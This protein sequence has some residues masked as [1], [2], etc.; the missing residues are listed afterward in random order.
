[1][2]EILQKVKL[3][4]SEKIQNSARDAHNALVEFFFPKI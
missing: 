2:E 4:T 3:N 1:L